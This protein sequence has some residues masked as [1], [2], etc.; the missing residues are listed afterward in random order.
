MMQ[1]RNV[2]DEVHEALAGAAAAQGLSLTRYLLRE[3][4]HLAKR[5]PAVQGNAAVIRE[6]QA[7]VRGQAGRDA[8]IAAVRDGRGD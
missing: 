5:A 4:E 8:L 2:P 7:R 1:I 3:L 6:V